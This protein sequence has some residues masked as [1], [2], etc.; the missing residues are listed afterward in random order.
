MN[1]YNIFQQRGFIT[2][3]TNE[4]KLSV[5]FAD[6]KISSYI[7]FDPTA[8]SLHIGS[9]IPI[10][11]LMHLQHNG[12]CPIAV[13]GGA[14][15]LI[16]D[17]SGK[18]KMRDL[19]SLEQIESNTFSIKKQLSH[20][21]DLRSDKATIVNNLSWLSSFNYLNFLRN[22]GRFF[23][24]NRMLSTESV[25]LR[26][27]QKQGLSFIE[28]NYAILQ[29]YDFMWLTKNYNCLLQMGGNDQ[30]GN[31]VAGVEFT[32]RILGKEVYG[33]TFPLI[34]TSTGMKMGKT[35]TGTIWLDSNLTSIYDF[36]Q[37]WIN[38]SDKDVIRFLKFFSFLPLKTINEL[39]QL[40]GADIREAKQIL[41]FEV[42]KIVHGE[43]KAKIAQNTALTIFNS[44]KKKNINYYN[45]VPT[46]IIQKTRF[47]NGIPAFKLLVE[48][49][50]C[51]SSSEAR[52]L[53]TQGGAYI[54]KTRLTT[55]NQLV[56]L[57]MVN[58]DNTLWL[59]SG[60]KKYH[61][62]LLKK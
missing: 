23:S 3:C 39:S 21:L 25:K 18:T 19:L 59:R 20:F 33:L 11:S 7:G 28:F 14:T 32:R 61:R 27:K 43:T 46:T 44:S 30:W 26:L 48:I 42:T 9:L 56:T 10:I 15:A 1:V 45:N 53:I 49:G 29:S 37:H 41:A 51:K 52:R 36:Y 60:K 38:T 57:N 6:K 58:K 31:I 5:L 12:H 22:I 2:Q 54:N 62:I 13:I 55:F 17:P 47:E 16:G 8:A 4:K 50:L 24:V 35:A 40:N 34:T